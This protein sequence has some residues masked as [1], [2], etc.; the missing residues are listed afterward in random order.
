[1]TI[2]FVICGGVVE[3]APGTAHS[4]PYDDQWHVYFGT[5]QYYPLSTVSLQDGYAV[6]NDLDSMYHLP[7]S[8]FVLGVTVM[9][10]TYVWPIAWSADMIFMEYVVKN[11]TTYALND[12]YIGIPMDFDIGDETGPAANDRCGIDLS[13]KMFYGWQEAWEPGIPPWRPGVVGLKLL[14]PCS[15]SSFKQF[16]PDL[17]P[18]A[19]R[20]WY[21]NMAGYNFISGVYEPYDTIW[22][23]PGDQRVM[24]T[25]GPFS[26]LAPGDSIIVD[27]VL[28]A[29]NDTIP[30][31][32]ELPYKA[33]KAQTC[34][35]T[36][37]HTAS[38]TDPNGGEVATG[39]YSVN[40]SATS[41]TGNALEVSLYLAS[42]DGIDT[43]ATGQS[44]TGSYFWD[45]ALWPDG[46]LYKI[47]VVANDTITFGGDVSDGIFTIDNPGNTP[48]TLVVFTPSEATTLSGDY[49]I[50]WFA[51]DPEFQDSLY[52]D[53][54]FKSQYDAVF[55]IIASNEENDSVYSWNTV[56]YR[57][58]SGILIVETHDEEFTVAET[59]QVYL[60]NQISGGTIDHIEGINNIVD[61]SVLVHE[62]QQITG[63]TY[64]LEF[65]EYRRVNVYYPEYIYEI[66]DSNT[67]VTVLDTYS[68]KN[69]YNYYGGVVTITDYSPIIDGFSIKA[70]SNDDPPIIQQNTF[71]N[72]SVRVILG[73]YPE[74][75]ITLYGTSTYTWWAYRGARMQLDWITHPSGGLTLLV[76][77]LDYGDTIPYKPYNR[78]GLN[79]DSAFGWCF[80]P[81]I[82]PNASPSDTLRRGYDNLIMLCGGMIRISLTVFPQVGDRWIVYPSEYA[83]PIKGNLY[84]FTPIGIAEHEDQIKAVNFQIYP[85]PFTKSLTIAYSLSQRQKINLAVYD[86]LGRQVRKLKS[87]TENPGQYKITWNGLDDRSRKVS[88]GVYF[89]RLETEGCKETKKF[90]MLK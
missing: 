14:S 50:T 31:C 3:Y 27:W 86:V 84:R 30:P 28:I 5:D 34:Y 69:G 35:E 71:Q 8:F 75:S 12:L 46:V 87:G 48:P 64:E 81:L 39:V 32:T 61:L 29:S 1:V 68:L 19:D 90:I 82:P 25:A 40:Y 36:G 18:S 77:D 42:P 52:V 89:C 47:A 17:E 37:W 9:Q 79:P 83:P 24:M 23:T 16:I 70:F 67:G 54:Y 38:V 58:G 51:R 26:S 15:L 59:V 56:P 11:D 85:V 73:I 44:N 63:H 7:D 88:A 21:L 72:D 20:E 60:L 33:D 6:Y 76:T 10:R 45:S 80:M 2:G 78:V 55:N 53:I 49:D 43:I 57:N 62:A 4:N 74:D 65:L 66:R 13:R 22:P 41:V